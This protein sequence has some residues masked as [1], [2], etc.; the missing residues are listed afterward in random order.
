MTLG[1][2][3][4]QEAGTSSLMTVISGSE[5]AQSIRLLMEDEDSVTS[6]IK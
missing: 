5:A 4:G 3:K 1:V 2:L 6:V